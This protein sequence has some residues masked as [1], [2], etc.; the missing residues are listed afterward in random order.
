MIRSGDDGVYFDALDGGGRE[1]R[2]RSRACYQGWRGRREWS[3]EKE[4]GEGVEGLLM[5]FLSEC[6]LV[7]GLLEFLD[8][9]S[10]LNSD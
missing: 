5:R 7:C 9:L 6:L 2:S 10:T 3:G 8:F 4:R 1:V